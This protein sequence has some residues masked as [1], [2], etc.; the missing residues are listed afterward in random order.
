[1]SNGS[2]REDPKIISETFANRFSSV[3]FTGSLN[4][5]ALRQA[6]C[7][8]MGSIVI[9]YECVCKRISSLDVEASME[10]DGF[11]HTLLSSYQAVAYHINII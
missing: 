5:S 8:N 4:S 2:L 1:M 9:T 7:G 6:F 3:Y 10:H 11:H